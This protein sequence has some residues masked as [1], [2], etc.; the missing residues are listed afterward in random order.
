MS[1]ESLISFDAPDRN[2][3]L[4]LEKW[5]AEKAMR[6]Q[7]M[8]LKERDQALREADVSLKRAE[9]ESSR[10]RNPLVVAILAATVA[11]LGNAVVAYTSGSAQRRL[12]ADKAEQA[13]ILEVIKT[14]NADKAAENLRFLLDAGLITDADI[15]SALVH[16][17]SNR[18]SGSGP[19]LPSP[20]ISKDLGELVSKFEGTTLK[21]Y[22][23][24]DGLVMI[25][26]G[27]I[28][29]REERDSGK[30][31]IDGQPVDFQ[32]GITESQARRLLEA[33]LEATGVQVDNLVTVKLTPSQRETLISFAFQVGLSA[34]RGS[35]LLRKV[36]M[37]EFEE[38]PTQLRRWV[39]EGGETVPG[40]VERRELEAE[41]WRKK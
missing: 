23:N 12:E 39:R 17:L 30:V 33:D 28:L 3:Q 38:V 7:E 35:T 41:Y 5:E 14:G 4:D 16:Y 6:A 27:H 21:P 37:G 19:A 9:H 10:W 36:N 29:T 13:R 18:K 15:R 8:A 20:T 22:K 34:F 40:L 25:G 24:A 2:F 32:S 26:S 31:T 11:A 1:T